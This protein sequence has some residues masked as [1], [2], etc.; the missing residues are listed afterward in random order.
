MRYAEQSSIA[1]FKLLHIHLANLNIKNKMCIIELN[2]IL[3]E[4]MN[5]S[6][7]FALYMFK[8]LKDRS[9]TAIL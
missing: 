6:M 9:K 5:A 4:R 1:R 3:N 7:R 2:E 8:I